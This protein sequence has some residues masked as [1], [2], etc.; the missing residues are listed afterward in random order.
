M[1]VF[2]LWAWQREKKAWWNMVRCLQA[3][4]HATSPAT[5]RQDW[6]S[7]QGDLSCQTGERGLSNTSRRWCDKNSRDCFQSFLNL[8]ELNI[9]LHENLIHLPVFRVCICFY[10]VHRH[11]YKVRICS[12]GYVFYEMH[13]WVSYA[14]KP[15]RLMPDPGHKS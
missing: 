4:R 2:S 15:V 13:T 12:C 6:I 9:F 5:H 7:G 1:E 11:V 14:S 3:I 8:H 10:A